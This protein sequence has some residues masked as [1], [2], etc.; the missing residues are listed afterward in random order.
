GTSTSV[1]SYIRSR[2]SSVSGLASSVR[3]VREVLR[4]AMA[5]YYQRITV[6]MNPREAAGA[7]A[8]GS[9]LIV[10]AGGDGT[11]SAAAAAVAGSGAA[12]GII[13]LGTLNHFA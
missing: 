11:V 8:R 6:F 4:L 7:I 1:G 9:T 2:K 12:L 3:G 13:P 5:P 10:A